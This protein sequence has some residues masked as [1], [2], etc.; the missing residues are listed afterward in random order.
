MMSSSHRP[1]QLME[2]RLRQAAAEAVSG[3]VKGSALL[4]QVRGMGLSRSGE[5]ADLERFEGR[6]MFEAPA[7]RFRDGNSEEEPSDP[8]D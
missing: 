3:S 8:A 4:R 2:C 5:A 7:P 1:D 6:A